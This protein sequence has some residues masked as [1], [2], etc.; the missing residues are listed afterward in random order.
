MIK[1]WFF[2]HHCWSLGLFL[3]F[4]DLMSL[5]SPD[6]LCTLNHLASVSWLLGFWPCTIKLGLAKQVVLWTCTTIY[7]MSLCQALSP[8]LPV[9]PLPLPCVSWLA[10]CL[11]FH[12]PILSYFE[13]ILWLYMLSLQFNFYFPYLLL[14]NCF[15]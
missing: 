2:G 4:E 5:Y 3:I 10:H 13:W 11:W 7:P 12:Y 6:G 8:L 14:H 9:F 1:L 15:G